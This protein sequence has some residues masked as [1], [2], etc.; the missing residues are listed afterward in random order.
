M[1]N[2]KDNCFSFN[3]RIKVHKPINWFNENVDVLIENKHNKT[4]QTESREVEK[5]FVLSKCI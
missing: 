2:L 4:L 1:F 5:Y 3:G